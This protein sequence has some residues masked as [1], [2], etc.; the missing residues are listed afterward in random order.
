LTN[1]QEILD[2]YRLILEPEGYDVHLSA[3]TYEDLKDIEQLRP[4]L[5]ILDFLI[6]AHQAGWQLLQR[7]KMY[8]PTNSLPILLCTAAVQEVREQEEYLREKGIPIVFKPFDLD[9]LLAA[10]RHLLG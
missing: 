6:G 2:L 7:L 8:P 10:I 9:E 5:I 4:D 1:T 3:Y